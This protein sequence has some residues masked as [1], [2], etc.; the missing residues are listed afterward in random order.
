[1][2]DIEAMFHQ[3]QVKPD[4]SNAL[5]FF[6]WPNGDLNTQPQEFM[7]TVHLFGGV[8]SPSCANFALRKTG[9]D[10]QGFDPEIVNTVKRNFY[11]DD[12]L[13]SVKSEKLKSEQGKG[14]REIRV[15]SKGD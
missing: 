15:K 7:M 8:S 12:C 14:Q 9:D 6:W 3:V 11:V 13:K 10:N 2:A 4:D 1:M 5:R